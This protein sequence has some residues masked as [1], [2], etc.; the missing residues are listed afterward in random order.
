M[1]RCLV[2]DLLVFLLLSIAVLVLG[3]ACC[4]ALET[5]SMWL[6]WFFPKSVCVVELVQFQ[7]EGVLAY[8]SSCGA[9]AGLLSF[10]FFLVFSLVQLTLSDFEAGVS[11]CRCSSR[12]ALVC[13]PRPHDF[14]C[15]SFF[16]PLVEE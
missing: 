8:A 16:H 10:G 2:F 15:W 14:K 1:G 12:C 6:A 13:I 3:F 5:A 7:L 9:Y 4:L 11:F